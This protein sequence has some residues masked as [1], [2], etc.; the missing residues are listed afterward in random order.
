[1]MEPTA[2]ATGKPF[3]KAAASPAVRLAVAGKAFRGT[4]K[5]RPNVQAPTATPAPVAAAQA[6]APASTPRLGGPAAPD[7][8][9]RMLIWGGAAAGVLALFLILSCRGK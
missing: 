4:P 7:M 6:G 3:A 8:R 5:M 2:T 1:M 9:R